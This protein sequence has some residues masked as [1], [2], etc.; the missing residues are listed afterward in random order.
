MIKHPFTTL[1]LAPEVRQSAR[2]AACLLAICAL[3]VFASA[4][5]FRILTFD[6]PGAT[7]SGSNTINAAGVI[8]GGYSDAGGVHGYIRAVDGS[9]TSFDIAGAISI[10]TSGI[11]SAEEIIGTYLTADWITHGFLRTPDGTVTTLYSPQ[12][13]DIYPTG[14]N[15]SG[16]IVGYF[17][18]G[19]THSFLRTRAGNFKTFNVLDRTDT[20]AMGI[21]A[22]GATTGYYSDANGVG[23][24]F[25]RSPR[26]IFTTFIVPGA[27][28]T[29]PLT[30]GCAY[31]TPVGLMPS[32]IIVGYYTDAGGICAGHGFLRTRNDTYI[33]IDVPGSDLARAVGVNTAGEVIG[34]YRDNYTGQYRGFFYFRGKV[35]TFDPPDSFYTNPTSINDAGWI[36]GDY[37]GHSFLLIPENNAETTP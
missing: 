14:I 23:R 5:K 36:T 19:S 11:N 16:T 3:S 15:A 8:A 22:A 24:G 13:Q 6:P 4:Q 2:F 25:L 28:N 31:T 21:N 20:T 26:G 29:A 9:F 35:T 17:F 33:V 27:F 18:D 30:P 10:Y 1:R 34:W 7:G 32:G 37:N 12:S